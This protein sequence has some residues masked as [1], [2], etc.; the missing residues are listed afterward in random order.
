MELAK[1]WSS[2]ESVTLIHVTGQRDFDEVSKNAPSCSGLDYRILPFG[3]MTEL[4]SLCDVAVTRAGAM[5]VG[6]LCLLGIPSVLVPLPGAPGDHQTK[7]AQQLVDVGGA[8]MINDSKLNAQILS[9]SI[10]EILEKKNTM[11][12]ALTSLARANA[13]LSI[14]E[15]VLK[16]AR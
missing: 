1:L 9:S 7:N 15:H 10:E 13:A 5:T 3:D 11:S 6:E 2:R 4:W 14:A 16:I 12:T 8:V